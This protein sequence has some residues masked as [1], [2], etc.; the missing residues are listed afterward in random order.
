MPPG[1]RHH[2]CLQRAW[3]RPAERESQARRPAFSWSFRPSLFESTASCAARLWMQ[4]GL[5]VE[6]CVVGRGCRAVEG[7]F[8][9]GDDRSCGTDWS[10]AR[11]VRAASTCLRRVEGG[12][13]CGMVGPAFDVCTEGGMG[14]VEFTCVVCGVC[15]GTVCRCRCL[16]TGVFSVARC[17][18]GRAD[19]QRSNM[20]KGRETEKR[21]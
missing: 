2:C 4:H 6:V 3:R 13:S 15:Y 17:R 1:A 7:G 5:G 8:R 19:V 21:Q 16:A 11:L 10:W 12:E 20:Q 14:D 18:K 9:G